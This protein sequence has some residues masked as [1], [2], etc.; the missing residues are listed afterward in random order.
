MN[1]KGFGRKHFG[2][3]DVLSGI[4]LKGLRKI[5]KKETVKMTGAPAK[6]RT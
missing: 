6:I 4:C 5:T 3:I 1:W 2:L